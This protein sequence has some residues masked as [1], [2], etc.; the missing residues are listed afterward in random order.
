MLLGRLTGVCHTDTARLYSRIG[1]ACWYDL[2]DL[3]N[4]MEEL[5]AE[6]E[7][8][9]DTDGKTLVVSVEK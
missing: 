3:W 7:R 4:H 9:G 8:V 2:N 1:T 5:R 6:R